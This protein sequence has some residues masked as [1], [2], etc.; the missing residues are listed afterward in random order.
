MLRGS[1]AAEAATE[2]MTPC[3]LKLSVA[4]KPDHRH[5]SKNSLGLVSEYPP[6]PTKGA[7]NHR[8]PVGIHRHWKTWKILL[9]LQLSFRENYRFGSKKHR[10]G[11]LSPISW[12]TEKQHVLSLTQV[13]LG[14]NQFSASHL[15]SSR[16]LRPS[17]LETPEPGNNRRSR[18]A[19][20]FHFYRIGKSR[21]DK[22]A[23]PNNSRYLIRNKLLF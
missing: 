23:K 20:D 2:K 12:P 1:S 21:R 5:L 22:H 10:S 7:T 13:G 16:W 15:K 17:V 6:Q 14:R 11:Q 9:S 3:L 18:E 19:C 4:G 8:R